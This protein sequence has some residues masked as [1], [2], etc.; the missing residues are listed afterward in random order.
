[1]DT[2]LQLEEPDDSRHT[3]HL[4]TSL[5][6]AKQGA[7]GPSNHPPNKC[8]KV[9]TAVI[10]VCGV[11]IVAVAVGVTVTKRS[12]PKVRKETYRLISFL[13]IFIIMLP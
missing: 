8:N 4:P 12:T 6:S 13:E 3:Q 1:M 11:I 10:V 7:R 2:E 5:E 9:I